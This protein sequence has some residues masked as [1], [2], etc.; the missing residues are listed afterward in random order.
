LVTGDKTIIQP[1]MVLAVDGSVTVPKSF[2]AQVG[3]SFIVTE[4]GY[5]EITHHP[6][7][8]GDVIL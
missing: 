5:D 4:S 6:K 1:G 7:A 3:D 8:I 2:R